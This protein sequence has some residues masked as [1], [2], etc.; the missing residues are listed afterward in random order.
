VPPAPFALIEQDEDGP[1]PERPYTKA[2]LLG[3]LATVRQN[4]QA[5][6][7]GLTDEGAQR[8]CRFGWGEVSFAEL[9]LYSMRHVAGHAAQLNLRL[10]Q[11][12]GSAPGW[13]TKARRADA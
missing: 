13:Q 12:V 6:L 7:E 5:T 3:Y 1:V 9:L 10:G 4:C 11:Q 8:P 2:E